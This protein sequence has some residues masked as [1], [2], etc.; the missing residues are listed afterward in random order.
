MDRAGVC[1]VVG[2]TAVRACGA[3]PIELL[4][5]FDGEGETGEFADDEADRRAVFETSVLRFS[6]N[7][8]LVERRGME[9]KRETSGPADEA[10]GITGSCARTAYESATS[11]A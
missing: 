11:G 1:R 8:R 3:V 7:D 10:D 2:G 5:R 9:G 6:S 4:L